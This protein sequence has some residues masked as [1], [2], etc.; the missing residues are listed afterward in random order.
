MRAILGVRVLCAVGLLTGCV[1]TAPSVSTVL[2]EP[3]QSEVMSG[4]LGGLH[5][6]AG[7]GTPIVLMVPGSGPTDRDGNTPP[8]VMAAPLKLLA[9]GLALEGISS[10]RVDKRGLFGSKGAGDPNAVTVDSYADDYRGWIDTIRAKTGS[11]CVFLLGHSEGASMVSAATIGREDVCG[12]ILVSGPGRSLGDILREQLKANPANAP[13]LD[14]ALAAIQA[15]EAGERVDTSR[16]NPAL[17]PLFNETVQPYL[18]SVLAVDPAELAKRANVPTLIL[19]G[20]TD[21]QTTMEDAR[22]LAEFSGGQLIV[23]DGVNHVLKQ[24]PA[25]R[26]ANIAT[27]SDPSLPIAPEV[28]DAVTAFV[29][30]Q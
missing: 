12:L 1:G 18:R 15:L 6:N 13:I 10:V 30:E 5:I 2:P 23:I 27:Y 22:R 9:E 21:I 11:D 20:T 8:S 19:Q 17:L 29:V 24:S 25:A 3:V 4:A 26:G 14:Q 7:N 16:L 28:V